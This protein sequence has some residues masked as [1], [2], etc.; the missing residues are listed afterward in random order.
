MRGFDYHR[1]EFGG[2]SADAGW[3]PWAVESGWTNTWVT[4]IL[5]L[6]QR[7][8]TL[9]SLEGELPSAD[10]LAEVALALGLPADGDAFA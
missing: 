6:R 5:Q 4:T 8:A 3:G 2:Q 1:W 10:L 7:Q 9:W